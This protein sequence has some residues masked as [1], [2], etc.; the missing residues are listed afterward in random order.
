[1]RFE[2][3]PAA[4][5]PERHRVFGALINAVKTAEPGTWMRVPLE[6]LAGKNRKEKRIA[7]LQAMHYAHLQVNTRIDADYVYVRLQS[8]V[9]Q[10][11][12]HKEK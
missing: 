6:D 4:L 12:A 11:V 7:V 3:V 8:N 5:A 10:P 2:P 1:M 9:D